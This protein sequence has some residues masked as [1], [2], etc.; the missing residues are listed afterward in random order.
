[1]NIQSFMDEIIE[2]CNHLGKCGIELG[3]GGCS[4]ANSRNNWEEHF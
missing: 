2:T 4:E 3:P 1:M